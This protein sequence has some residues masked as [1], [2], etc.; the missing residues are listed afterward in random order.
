MSN[1]PTQEIV[2]GLINKFAK[3]ELKDAFKDYKHTGT[4]VYY[5]KDETVALL[6]IR[7][8]NLTSGEKWIRPFRYDSERKNYTI[9]EPKF[10]Q[11]KPLYRLSELIKR[12]DE[13][14]W[15]CEGESC[16]E[17]MESYG[18]LA[19]TSGSANSVN[20][21]DFFPLAN[22]KVNFF[23][24]YDEAG[25]KY[26]E[27]VTA[28]LQALGCTIRWVNVEQLHLPKGGDFIDW[29]EAKGSITKEDI[30]QLPLID[31]PPLED[32]PVSFCPFDVRD[33]GVFYCKA[34]DTTIWLCSKL[35][36]TALSRDPNNENWGRVLEFN[37]ADGHLHHWVMPDTFLKGN[38][39][40]AITELLRL[41]LTIHPGLKQKRYLLEY[42]AT[43]FVETKVRCI[44]HTGWYKQS[45]ILPNKIYYPPLENQEPL[46]YRGDC[47]LHNYSYSGTLDEWTY[48]ISKYCSGNSRLMFAV[49]LAF[50]GPLVGLLG[51]ESG[52]F[53][54]VGESSIG[55]STALAVAASVYSGKNY[56]R[57]LRTTDN[58][59]EGLAA[60]HNHAL[61][62]LD[63][64]SQL[65]SRIAG[66][67]FYMLANGQGKA[68]A[69]RTGQARNIATW[70]LLFLTSGEL[71]LRAHLESAGQTIKAGQEIRS[72]NIS[73]DAGEG[74]GIFEDL[75]G[76]KDG[77][78]LSNYLKE[79]CQRSYGSAID[80]FLTYL[81]KTDKEKILKERNEIAQK[82]LTRIKG[83]NAHGQV[84][85]VVERFA[86]V[87]AAG[88]L[89]IKWGIVDWEVGTCIE[90]TFTCFES[91]INDH[92]EGGMSSSEEEK[93]VEQVRY[94]FES[95]SSR[96]D[97]FM[98]QS[99]FKGNRAGFRSEAQQGN[100]AGD[101]YVF[102]TTF[103]KEICKN[104]EPR[105]VAT[106]L[107]KKGL[108]YLPKRGN[109]MS[110]S[111]RVP[112]ANNKQF[113]LY[114][115]PAQIVEAREEE[116]KQG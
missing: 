50:A 88:E 34:G 10:D 29:M 107:N 116:K 33:D 79:Q 9:G 82:F 52:G 89:A 59:L 4:H 18:L 47:T 101:Y 106:I 84:K 83:D 70:C 93:I 72:I 54:L 95:Q 41:G 105:L 92:R 40:L 62:I 19:T 35:E 26:R 65:N 114:H 12:T 44:D 61:L 64:L 49:A 111:I 22:R 112:A 78:S 73:A 75:H 17:A 90:S 77:S 45:F 25:I 71:S 115:F 2:Q 68:R 23:C 86:L 11:G 30:P 32:T 69:F 51:L 66:D 67:V 113:R 80:A 109:D 43:T 48:N 108:L 7:L 46:K 91:W 27:N 6:K 3:N 96:F 103:K 36:I 55:K 56:V 1:L 13:T 8:K 38:G 14:I 15:F 16:V 21:T 81:V 104:Y 31:A 20:T 100:A 98:V 85:R 74:Y 76:H 24:D 87:A 110:V 5:D 42:L 97:S 102:T 99:S 94:F 37:D 60:Q 28:R 58:G 39:E 63:E 57:T 53:H